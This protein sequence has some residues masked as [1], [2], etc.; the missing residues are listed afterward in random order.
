MG[1]V[2]TFESNT[3]GN[4][5]NIKD[6][7]ITPSG[8]V[9]GPGTGAGLNFQVDFVI[10]QAL[11]A[12]SQAL[13]DP[14]EDLR[15]S[16]EPRVVTSDG[17]VTCWD[18]RL[19]HPERVTEAK[20]KP[21]RVEIMEWLDRVEIGTQQ[22]ADCEFEL[23]YGR[24]ASPI[25]SAIESL[26]RIAK[27]ADGNV[28]RFKNLV[29]LERNSDIEAVLEHL[30]AEPHV[31]L[32]RVRLTPIDPQR[33]ERDIQFRTRLLVYEPA[34]PRL[35][36]ILFT[37]FHK[38][39]A[40]RATYNVRDLIK[41]ANDD[42][43]EFFS[44]PTFLSPSQL[45]PVVSSAICI[46]QHCETGLPT[47]VLAAGIGCT[48]REIE[49]SLS[50]HVGAG[51]LTSDEGCWDFDPLRPLPVQDNGLRLIGKALSQ[52]LEFI[53]TN[54]KNALGWRQVPNA[55]AL[56]KVCES[57]DS[58]L[59]SALFWKLDKLLK[60]TGN[61]QLVLEVANI[62]LKAA[63]RPPRTEAKSKGEAVALICGRSW[64]FQR[65][66][67]LAEA[68]ADGAKSLKL[69]E[70][71]GWCRNTAFCLK[72]LG[73]LFRMEAERK[74]QDKAKFKELLGSS[75]NHLDRA[76]SSFLK[77]TELSD[78]DRIAEVGDCQS[79]LGRAYLVAG[80][81]VKAR[82]AAC[83]AIDR[84]T[85]TASKDY[86]DL[87][88][89]LGDLAYAQNDTDAAVSFYNEAI[90]TAGTS[91]AERS[92]IAAR[93]Y[94]QK[95]HATKSKRSF[96]RA[97]EIWAKLEEDELADDARW[98]SM[99][100]GGRVPSVAEQVLKDEDPSVRVETIRLHEA[101]L[102]GLSSSRGRRSE[103]GQGY[104]NELLPQA[105]RNVAVRHVEW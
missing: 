84:L 72:C 80:D 63:R 78:A 65:I 54:K 23:F 85:D 87:Q 34:R 60:R 27:E 103:P 94:L 2:Q 96:D 67:R 16:M 14:L 3:L 64:V 46:L 11:E 17:N 101:Q 69:G 70:D 42:Q 40:Q 99:L 35:Y 44:P 43:I 90:H 7:R 47:E 49:D 56:A 53:G 61:K 15:I 74:R 62:S 22:D 79:L 32:L 73:R 98:R 93:A 4:K 36:N 31:S 37:K 41:E 95:G 57:E 10:L 1:M 76:I 9:G 6:R 97:A 82:A 88:I 89:L 104:W 91:D 8:A 18:V 5:K 59:V 25:L 58:E 83:E 92:E 75:I 55:I 105:R 30:K 102:A 71:I 68:R 50:K 26:C 33:L 77:T 21:K 48:A 12:I 29:D 100:L 45:A 38:G 24:G 20:L 39:I 86:A 19:S 52:L 66:N 28:D 81:L 51:G 13:A